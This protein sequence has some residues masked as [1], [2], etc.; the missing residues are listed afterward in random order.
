MSTRCNKVIKQLEVIKLRSETNRSMN[1]V[2]DAEGHGDGEVTSWQ[3]AVARQK[4]IPSFLYLR[5][6]SGNGLQG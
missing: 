1:R 2:G 5:M 6:Q 3:L 4:G